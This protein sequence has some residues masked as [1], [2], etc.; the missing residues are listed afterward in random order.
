MNS[1]LTFYANVRSQWYFSFNFSNQN[2]PEVSE[3]Q[4]FEHLFMGRYITVHDGYQRSKQNNPR[5]RNVQTSSHQYCTKNI[6]SFFNVVKCDLWI[7]KWS[8]FISLLLQIHL[9]VP[10]LTILEILSYKSDSMSTKVETTLDR[11][12]STSLVQVSRDSSCLTRP[13]HGLSNKWQQFTYII[14]VSYTVIHALIETL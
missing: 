12:M 2:A 3:F 14:P 11:K 5:S 13:S 6:W 10:Q 8:W 4:R 9:K 1:L 7:S